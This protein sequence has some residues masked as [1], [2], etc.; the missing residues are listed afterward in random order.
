MS[1]PRISKH[2]RVLTLLAPL[3]TLAL[4]ACDDDSSTPATSVVGS[5][6]DGGGTDVDNLTDDDNGVGTVLPSE[7]SPRATE[8]PNPNAGAGG[9]SAP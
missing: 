3:A 1:V 6:V 8:A 9:G 5:D 7:T 4:T 2:A